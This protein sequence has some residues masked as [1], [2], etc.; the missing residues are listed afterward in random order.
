ME[1]RNGDLKKIVEEAGFSRNKTGVAGGKTRG[2]ER[3]N[4]ET[5]WREG[6]EELTMEDLTNQDQRRKMAN[7][8]LWTTA[9]LVTKT[10]MNQETGS[11]K[12]P[13]TYQFQIDWGEEAEIRWR[14]EKRRG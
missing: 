6:G 5:T 12:V 14:I 8:E 3:S 13:S 10:M 1:G 11:T 7:A 9:G 4:S 2:E